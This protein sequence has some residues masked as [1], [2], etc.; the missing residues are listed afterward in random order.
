MIHSTLDKIYFKE[1]D[2]CETLDV[3]LANLFSFEGYSKET[4]YDPE[5]KH[6][7]CKEL[8]RRS[9][10]DLLSISN[11]YFPNTTEEQ[12]MQSLNSVGIRF[13]HCNDINKI[14]F[15]FNWHTAIS[16]GF[17]S[18]AGCNIRDGSYTAKELQTILDKIQ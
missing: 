2:Q 17:M 18:Y 8:S 13:Y 10:E 5:F 9:F 15:H 14:V 16:N 1:A 4:Y 7:Q 3:L 12:L 6:S 11:T